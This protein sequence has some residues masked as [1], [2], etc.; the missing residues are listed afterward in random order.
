MSV[1][2]QKSRTQLPRTNTSGTACKGHDTAF[3][4]PCATL[5]ATQPRLAQ[6]YAANTLTR[7]CLWKSA[8]ISP[9]PLPGDRLQAPVATWN[10]TA[11]GFSFLILMCTFGQQNPHPIF[12]QERTPSEGK[13]Q[14]NV[15]KFFLGKTF[16]GRLC[17]PSPPAQQWVKGWRW[18]FLL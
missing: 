3:F 16:Q 11:I 7:D 4:M 18:S 10:R 13:R 6:K 8:L 14:R 15:W 17:R 2:P 1:K 12:V 9:S 5:G